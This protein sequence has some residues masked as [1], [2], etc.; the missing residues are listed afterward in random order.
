MRRHNY[1]DHC[2]N[3]ELGLQRTK[4]KH[5]HDP[6]DELVEKMPSVFLSGSQKPEA[7]ELDGKRKT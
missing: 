3:Q 7:T 6:E 4:V 1:W 5:L 2:L